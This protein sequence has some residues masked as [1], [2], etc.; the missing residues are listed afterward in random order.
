MSQLLKEL[1]GIINE[2]DQV[3]QDAP[4]AISDKAGSK[5]LSEPA[6][7]EPVA[8]EPVEDKPKSISSLFTEADEA[9]SL[10]TWKKSKIYDAR[11]SKAGEEIET[12]WAR[13]PHKKILSRQDGD[14][15]VIRDHDDVKQMTAVKHADFKTRF[16]E[17]RAGQQPDAEGYQQY[18]SN[19]KYE[20]IS[21]A[22]PIE[23]FGKG[24]RHFS[25]DK[26]DI[27][28]RQAKKAG[29]ESIIT[30]DALKNDYLEVK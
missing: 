9:G 2:V 19:V 26:G 1:L 8:E 18:L 25:A 21:I 14:L 10:G 17:L 23:F 24:H 20:T 11:D 12:T 22:E 27:V 16:V 4:D 15:M 5:D 13:M 28:I 3:Q 6:T 29:T 7:K 30:A